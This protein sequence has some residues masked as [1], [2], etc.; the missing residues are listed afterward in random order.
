MPDSPSPSPDF[1]PSLAPCP[2][3]GG[4]CAPARVASNVQIQ[5][6]DAILGGLSE[7]RVVVCMAC[8]YTRFYALTPQVLWPKR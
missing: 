1:A 3:C 7:L 2:E 6:L 5:R 8:G 4:A